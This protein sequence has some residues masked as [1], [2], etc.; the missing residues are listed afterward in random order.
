MKWLYKSIALVTAGFLMTVLVA[1]GVC[2]ANLKKE[3]A[4]SIEVVDSPTKFAGYIYRST[5][6]GVVAYSATQSHHGQ[7]DAL[8]WNDCDAIWRRRAE[9]NL[10]QWM[11]LGDYEPIGFGW[12]FP[13]LWIRGENDDLV[14]FQPLL[15]RIEW[16]SGWLVSESI[17]RSDSRTPGARL[18]LRLPVSPIWKYVWLDSLCWALAIGTAFLGH[19]VILRVVRRNKNCCV[20][21]GYDL[22]GLREG[23]VCPECGRVLANQHVRT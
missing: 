23:Q 14:Q 13:A 12:P 20:S 10:G 5:G 8:S 2:A 1:W 3:S 6:F 7:N 22:F 16:E 17:T 18:P 4:D 15:R 21:C 19:Q 11:V 9:Q